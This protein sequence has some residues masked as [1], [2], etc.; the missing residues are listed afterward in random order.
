MKN[1][2]HRERIN[3]RTIGVMKFALNF[4]Q[5]TCAGRQNTLCSETILSV[6]ST[7]SL[8]SGKFSMEMP[9]YAINYLTLFIEVS[10]VYVCLE[11]N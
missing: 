11:G 3:A 9:I 10:R 6:N 2:I 1:I 8:N 7:S 5:P 4:A